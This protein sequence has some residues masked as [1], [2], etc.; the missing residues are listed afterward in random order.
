MHVDS[1][2]NRDDKEARLLTT[3]IISFSKNKV[4]TALCIKYAKRARSLNVNVFGEQ[5][6]EWIGFSTYE[7]DAP[8]YAITANE[9]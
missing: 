1:N 8:F 7:R 9:C 6:D 3:S 4:L 5:W 2:L